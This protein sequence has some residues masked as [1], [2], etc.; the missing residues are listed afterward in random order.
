MGRVRTRRRI[1]F[2]SR[3]I[4]ISSSLRELG[5]P[6]IECSLQRRGA[7]EEVPIRIF[8]LWICLGASLYALFAPTAAPAE[9][10]P[11][12]DRPWMSTTAS[13]EQRTR[14]LLEAM[15]QDEKL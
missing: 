1:A 8:Y 15:T 12:A 11:R 5:C 10:A 6:N 3:A 13:A 2:K 14:L 9:V 7:G 4:S